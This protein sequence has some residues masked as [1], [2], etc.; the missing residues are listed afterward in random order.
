MTDGASGPGV[1]T[2][3]HPPKLVLVACDKSQVGQDTVGHWQ[4]SPQ[5]VSCTE[6]TASF[7]PW[8]LLTMCTALAEQAAIKCL[9]WA[10]AT[11]NQQGRALPAWPENQP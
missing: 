2:N 4:L 1:K 3:G 11:F 6:A 9:K 10:L 8:N 5:L 7:P